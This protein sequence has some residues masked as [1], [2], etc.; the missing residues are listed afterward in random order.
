MEKGCPILLYQLRTQVLVFVINVQID[1]FTVD[2]ESPMEITVMCKVSK[3]GIVHFM[4]ISMPWK[5]V[6]FKTEFNVFYFW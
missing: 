2:E 1:D 3:W 5:Q 4:Y 6:N